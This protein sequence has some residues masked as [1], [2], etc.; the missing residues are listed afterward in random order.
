MQKGPDLWRRLG[1]I[2]KALLCSAILYGI[3]AL[4][5]RFPLAQSIAGLLTLVLALLTIFQIA[6]RA[7]RQAI[8][9]LRNRLITTYLFIAVVPIVLILTLV[10]LAGWAILGQMAVYLVNTELKHREESLHRQADALAHVPVGDPERGIRRMERITRS[11]F[12][13]FELT[14]HGAQ[15]VHYP[16]LGLLDPPPPAWGDARELVLRNEG[17]QDRLYA[18]AHVKTPAEEVTV[19]APVTHEFLADLVSGLGDI[20]FVLV[21]HLERPPLMGHPRQSRIPEPKNALDFKIRGYYPVMV[22]HWSDPNHQQRL[23]LVVDT[24]ISAVLG[25]VFQNQKVDWAEFALGFFVVLSI[26]FLIIEMA[27]LVYGIRLSRTITG[28]VHELY[29]GTQ[30]VKEGDFSYRIP[31]KGNDQLAELGTSFNTM[32]E[33]LGRLIV[34]AKEKERLESELAIAR[35]VQNQLFPKDVPFTRSLELKGVCNPARMV[36]GDYYDFMSL[37]D[38]ALAFAIGDVAGK[39]ISAALLMATIQST[40]RTQLTTPNGSG[41]THLSTA[42]LVANLNRQLYATTAPEKY[43]T[44]YFAVYDDLDHVLMYTNAGHLAPILLRGSDIST[45]DST[46]T[47]VGAFPIARYGEKSVPLEQG[48]ILVAYTDGIVEPEN[49][50]GEMFG[51]ERLQ[52]LL[53]K[54]SKD[55]SSEII[56]RTMEAVNQWTGS[57]ELQDDMTMVVARRL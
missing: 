23:L 44:F 54:H 57:S 34:V 16:A 53:V 17:G 40:M 12:P 2:G 46:G 7:M 45:L 3:L 49:A 36:S 32:T 18:W 9:R 13:Q 15:D 33:N 48:D 30:H 1:G 6:R 19:V 35:E 37:S 38:S 28:A 11:L 52:E 25:T 8:W 5:G 31:V 22:P 56:A 14:I 21:D 51:E 55:D 39:G 41:P 20:N 50:Y 27:S 42:K 26:M 24:R 43:A 4:I 29:E 47:V 10:G